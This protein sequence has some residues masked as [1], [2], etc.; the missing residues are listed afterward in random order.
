M[1][2]VQG[3]NLPNP[4]P[5]RVGSDYQKTSGTRTG[6]QVQNLGHVPRVG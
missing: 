3:K 1:L 2:V 6:Y 4:V 5:T